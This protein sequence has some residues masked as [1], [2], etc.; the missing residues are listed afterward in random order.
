[1]DD[2]EPNL[3]APRATSQ[4]AQYWNAGAEVEQLELEPGT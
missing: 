4:S 2:R 3:E 1:M